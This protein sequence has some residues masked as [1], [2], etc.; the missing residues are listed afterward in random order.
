MK[1]INSIGYGGK[2][3][4]IGILFAFIIPIGIMLIPYKCIPLDVISKISFLIGILILILFTIWLM[5]ELRQDK[6][7]NAHY[8]KNR[9]KKILIQS[10]QFECQACGNQH[11]KAEDKSC[12]V[13]GI[14]FK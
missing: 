12:S 1:K 7:I 8:E 3:I 6:R 9:D 11:V 2:V 14:V 4:F 5:I 13:C 10:G